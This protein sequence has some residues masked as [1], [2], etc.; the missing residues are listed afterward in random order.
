[1]GPSDLIVAFRA[2]VARSVGPC[3]MPAPSWQVQKLVRAA[4][5]GTKDG[6]ERASAAVKRGRSFIRTKSFVSAGRCPGVHA[7]GRALWGLS[8]QGWQGAVALRGCHPLT[9]VRVAWACRSG[10]ACLPA[11]GSHLAVGLS[12]AAH[13]AAENKGIVFSLTANGFPPLCT[14]LG[15][16]AW[17]PPPLSSLPKPRGLP[18]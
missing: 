6:L 15:A 16:P 14:W 9:G 18:S 10:T 1:M 11:A 17:V 5:E 3:L 4:K 13:A 7:D 12:R 8:W 2:G